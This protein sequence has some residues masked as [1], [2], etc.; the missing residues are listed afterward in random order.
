MKKILSVVLSLVIATAAF[1]LPVFAA[2]F[3]DVKADKYYYDSVMQCAD[4]GFVRGY[5]DGTFRPNGNITRAEFAVIMNKVLELQDAANN[6][7]RDVKA[8]K[9][10]EKTVDMYCT[11][12]TPELR[13]QLIAGIR[14]IVGRDMIEKAMSK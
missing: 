8:G 5:E 1:S 4:K 11:F 3:S 6:T 14:Q 9:D 2:D 12:K 13:L 7:F 10:I